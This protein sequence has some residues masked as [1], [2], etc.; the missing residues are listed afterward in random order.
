MKKL[1]L[2]GLG[3]GL[4]HSNL[5]AQINDGGS[6]PRS[7]A[8]GLFAPSD[9]HALRFEGEVARWQENADVLPHFH[10]IG[11]IISTNLDF[12][13]SG[14]WLRLEDGS[15]L[16]RLRL[17]APQAKAINLYFRNFHLAPGTKLHVYSPDYSQVLGGFGAHNN[18]ESGLFAT[19]LIQGEE[20]I[21][22]FQEPQAVA[23]QSRLT[24]EGLNYVFRDAKFNRRDFGDSEP[25]HI[26]VNCPEG[27]GR[28][29][30]RDAVSRI[31]GRVGSNSGWC[32]G[33][34]V[35]N[36][37]RD[38]RAF[39]LT[40]QHCATTSSGSL[41]STSDFNQWVFYFNFQ[42]PN[43]NN[44]A[45][46]PTV[47]TLTGATL[48]AHSNDRGGQDGSDFLLLE[49]NSVPP[50]SY[51]AYYAGW[52]KRNT[53][54][55]SGYCIHHPFGDLK[56]I[57]T[58]SATALSDTYNNVPNTHWF[59][60]WVAT[61]SGHSSTEGGSSGSPLYN[62]EGRI[63]GS[64]T[65]GAASCANPNAGDYYGKF[66]YHWGSNGTTSARRLRDWLDPDNTNVNFLNGSYDPVATSVE[67]LEL[68]PKTVEVFPNPNAGQVQLRLAQ[69][70]D[71][72]VE[73][74][75]LQGR[76]L[77]QWQVQEAQHSLQFQDLPAGIYFLQIRGEQ[78]FE[79]HKLMTNY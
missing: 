79:T 3:L 28:T 37:R 45:A 69:A 60:R 53:A 47:P 5:S 32:T 76:S 74:F 54:A 49:L 44:L 30:Q 35:N 15:R 73:L 27:N 77:R 20:L 56:K 62:P 34:L 11:H 6:R 72:Q 57:S 65:G 48:R 52:D 55:S 42:S 22:E 75:D 39:Y 38:G 21:L 59:V 33:S 7:Q 68:A 25:C 29:P 18:H 71:L 8:L 64:L 61:T 17:R 13:N 43:C 41:T 4:L 14:T 26:N 67:S 1:F 24:I 23:G 63:V 51:N 78:I 10:V 58:F 9:L 50:A 31:L 46:E 70:Q 40:A 19:E 16:W 36:T 66:S 2:L 12:E